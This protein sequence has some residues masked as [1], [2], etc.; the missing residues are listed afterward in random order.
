[1]RP[2]PDSSGISLDIASLEEMDPLL[3]KNDVFEFWT[4]TSLCL[5]KF[6]SRDS[7]FTNADVGEYLIIDAIN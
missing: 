7:N 5:L 1:L 4:L 2:G 6:Q 3:E